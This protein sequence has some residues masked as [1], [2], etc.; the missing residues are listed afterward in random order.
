MTAELES[1]PPLAWGANAAAKTRHQEAKLRHEF[2]TIKLA[3]P[4]RAGGTAVRTPGLDADASYLAGRAELMAYLHKQRAMTT[5]HRA[6]DTPAGR[7]G[8]PLEISPPA[9]RTARLPSLT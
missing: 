3:L 2:L 5:G 9:A 8:G 1:P 6:L 7:A 4:Y